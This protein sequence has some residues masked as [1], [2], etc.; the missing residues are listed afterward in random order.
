MRLLRI[1]PQLGEAESWYREALRL[2]PVEERDSALTNLVLLMRADGNR[3]K[4]AVDLIIRCLS[5]NEQCGEYCGL[6]ALQHVAKNL[7]NHL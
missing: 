3:L 2:S 4:E 6:Y 7:T 5:Y 1:A